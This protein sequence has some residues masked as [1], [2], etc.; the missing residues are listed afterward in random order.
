MACPLQA[1]IQIL[2]NYKLRS[3][4]LPAIKTG[5]FVFSCCITVYATIPFIRLIWLIRRAVT[6]LFCYNPEV[7]IKTNNEL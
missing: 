5:S 7:G 6:S 4:K 3:Q 2:I 1:I